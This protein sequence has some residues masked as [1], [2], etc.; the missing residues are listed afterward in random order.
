MAESERRN[1]DENIVYDNICLYVDIIIT[2]LSIRNI[3]YLENVTWR[4]IRWW[5]WEIIKQRLITKYWILNIHK[6][7]IIVLC[8]Q[9]LFWSCK[10]TWKITYRSSRRELTWRCLFS[11]YDFQTSETLFKKQWSWYRWRRYWKSYARILTEYIS[12]SR[13]WIRCSTVI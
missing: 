1:D 10:I 6:D 7:W 13:R 12:K 4:L 2:S 5:N 9:W 3:I 8:K 11:R